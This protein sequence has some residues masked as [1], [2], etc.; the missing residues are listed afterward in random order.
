MMKQ[1]EKAEEKYR[2][3]AGKTE[4]EVR[5]AVGNETIGIAEQPF[6]R[7]EETAATAVLPF[8]RTEEEYYVEKL[9][10]IGKKPFYS[11][12]K[13]LFDIFASGIGILLLFIPMLIIA[14]VVA[15]SSKGGAF[16]T[17]ERLGLN[18]R[19]FKLVKFRSM[20]KDAEK[21]GAQW[22]NGDQDARITKVGRFLRKTR[23]DG[24]PQLFCIFIGTMTI[25]GPRPE[26]EIF[27]EKFEEYVHGFSERL[28]VKPGLTGL[29]QINGG[30]DLKPEEK[31]VYDIEYIKTR[32][33]RLDL[34]IMFKTVAVIFNHKGAK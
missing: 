16:Y 26:R 5:P 9:G 13:R 31:V 1:S 34:K 24:L 27:Y 10:Q 33:I 7:R 23:L 14:A 22:S 12:V 11:F 6:E 32:S 29:A 15:C 20:R 19:K 18:G 2:I 8:E 25:V 30:Y 4:N 17:Q 21:N 3:L 28:K